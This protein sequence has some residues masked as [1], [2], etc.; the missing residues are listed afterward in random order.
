MALRLVGGMV[1]KID[2]YSREARVVVY[3]NRI[4]RVT[5]RAKMATSSNDDSGGVANTFV[6]LRGKLQ[7][8][9]SADGEGE[10]LL[11]LP[12]GRIEIKIGVRHDIF[13]ELGMD[14]NKFCHDWEGK[15]DNRGRHRG[16]WCKTAG[17]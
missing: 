17:G 14:R 10:K 6:R 1:V 8:V 15:N 4:G 2:G 9:E 13:W 5:F 3:W 11:P 7:I 16:S 12:I